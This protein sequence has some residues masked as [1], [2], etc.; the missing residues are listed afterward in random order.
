MSFY[1]T[2]VSSLNCIFRESTPS[3]DFGSFWRAFFRQE[4]PGTQFPRLCTGGS[5]ISGQASSIH[6]AFVVARVLTVDY[7]IS[8]FCLSINACRDDA[9]EASQKELR[10]NCTPMLSLATKRVIATLVFGA[11][12]LDF[13]SGC[14]GYEDFEGN[15]ANICTS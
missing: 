12:F 3:Y 10:L 6:N 15:N 7:R 9:M 5:S 8:S 14:A 2:I 11:S 4:S 1:A 13:Y